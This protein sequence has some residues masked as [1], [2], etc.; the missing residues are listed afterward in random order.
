MAKVATPSPTNQ[1]NRGKE[2]DP[3]TRILTQ[4][5]YNASNRLDLQIVE[6]H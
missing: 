5:D 1:V 6:L 4:T 2:S 3:K